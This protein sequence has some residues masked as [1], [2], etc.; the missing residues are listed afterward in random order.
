[1]REKVDAEIY[2]Q[3]MRQALFPGSRSGNKETKHDDAA[4]SLIVR[5]FSK[6]DYSQ[7]LQTKN[8]STTVAHRQR[9]AYTLAP[10]TS[11]QP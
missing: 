9:L 11:A 4:T 1:M 3:L 2:K 8:T 10:M 6:R 7:I 5:A